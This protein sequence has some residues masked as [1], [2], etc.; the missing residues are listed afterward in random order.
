M[1][2]YK[3]KLPTSTLEILCV[4]LPYDNVEAA[5]KSILHVDLQYDEPCMWYDAIGYDMPTKKYM[6]IAVGTGHYW[7]E[8]FTRDMHIGTVLLAGGSL[9]LH[10]F[11]VEAQASI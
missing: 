1:L 4:D 11:L 7:E 10:Y 3:E 5:R 2:I 6:I 8:T 9:V